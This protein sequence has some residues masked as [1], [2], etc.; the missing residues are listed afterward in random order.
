MWLNSRH[1]HH[2]DG[3]LNRAD[4]CPTTPNSGQAENYGTRVG[5]ACEDSDG[6]GVLDAAD[7]FPLDPSQS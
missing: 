1:P 4:N 3:D 6:D 5:D 2:G 7:A